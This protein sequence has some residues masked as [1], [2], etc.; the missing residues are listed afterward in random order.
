VVEATVRIGRRHRVPACSW[1]HAGD[2]NVHSSFLFAAD[3]DAGRDRALAAAAAVVAEAVA[4]GGTVS[5]EHGVGVTKLEHL[6]RHADPRLL[7]LQ[8]RLKEVFDAK[9]LLNPGKAL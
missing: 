6:R 7:D 2:G 3:D 1:G 4:L 9:G 5:G 8:R